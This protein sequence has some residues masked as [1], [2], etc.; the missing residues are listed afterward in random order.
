MGTRWK[1]PADWRNRSLGARVHHLILQQ[2]IARPAGPSE[3]RVHIVLNSKLG[4]D[5][6]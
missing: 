6:T 5:S 4:K 1:V 3:G 2:E